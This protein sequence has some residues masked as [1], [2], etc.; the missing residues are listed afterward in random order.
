MNVTLQELQVGATAK[1]K[2]IKTENST[3]QRLTTMGLL[4]GTSIRKIQ[5]APLGD[6]IAIEFNGQRVSLRQAE[7]AFIELEPQ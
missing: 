5:I 1:I 3:N 7:A 6:P 4:P 2:T